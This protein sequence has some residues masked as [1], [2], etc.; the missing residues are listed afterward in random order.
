[1]GLSSHV[2]SVMTFLTLLHLHNV[3]VAMLGTVATSPAFRV[4][5]SSI[6]IACTVV[7]MFYPGAVPQMHEIMRYTVMDPVADVVQKWSTWRDSDWKAMMENTW[8]ESR[9]FFSVAAETETSNS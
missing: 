3:R 1:M 2:L 4:L 6:C 5:A 7:V 9:S 8:N